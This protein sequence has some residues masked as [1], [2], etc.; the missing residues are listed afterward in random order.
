MVRFQVFQGIYQYRETS[1]ATKQ[2]LNR[3]FSLFLL[4]HPVKYYKV[5]FLQFIFTFYSFI[6]FILFS[7][8]TYYCWRRKKKTSVLCRSD[9]IWSLSWMSAKHQKP[10]SPNCNR[11]KRI[12]CLVVQLVLMEVLFKYGYKKVS[13]TSNYFLKD[14]KSMFE[15]CPQ[16]SK[17]IKVFFLILAFK[18]SFPLSIKCDSPM[19]RD[20][21]RVRHR[22]QSRQSPSFK[23]KCL[24]KTTSDIVPLI[25]NPG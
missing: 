24:F 5:V 19:S 12:F 2:T 8:I 7:E 11:G 13:S 16:W 23:T 3:Y 1:A 20:F 6:V 22:Q 18:R 14:F 4:C 9:C 21:F 25:A 10:Y 17:L 15:Q